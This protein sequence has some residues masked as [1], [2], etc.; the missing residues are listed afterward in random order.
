MFVIHW[1]EL[2]WATDSYLNLY[3]H[4]GSILL[5]V[6]LLTLQIVETPF[7]NFMLFA[8]CCIV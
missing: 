6:M 7:K 8:P 3:K 1:I 2:V 5:S 4:V